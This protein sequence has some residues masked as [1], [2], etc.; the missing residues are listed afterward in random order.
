MLGTKKLHFL[1]LS[2]F[3]ILHLSLTSS[4]PEVTIFSNI[5]SK[6][7]TQNSNLSYPLNK[8]VLCKSH[9]LYFKTSLGLYPISAIN[10]TTKILTI[11]HPSC[12]QTHNYL[13]PTLL[14]SALPSPPQPNSLFLFNCS[15]KKHHFSPSIHNYT[16]LD[17][18]GK[19]SSSCL[20]I[21]DIEKLDLG[22][23]PR[24]LNCSHYS[25][26]YRRSLHDDEY[27]LG[28]RIS[29]DIPDH[30]PNICNECEKANGNCGIG[31][32][33]VCHPKDCSKFLNL[34]L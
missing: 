21:E 2:F 5:C 13:S 14:S 33:C 3:L 11:S 15:I 32:R 26:V 28:T 16:F 24:D 25:P 27:E 31:L 8:M 12:S 17:S 22:F 20:V 6:I 29:F 34:I 9:K 23:H 10:Y 30:A 19:C 7:Q 18:C 1:L 4:T